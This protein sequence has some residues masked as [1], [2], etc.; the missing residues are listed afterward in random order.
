MKKRSFKLLFLLQLEAERLA[1]HLK[2]E[3]L[4]SATTSTTASGVNTARS[5]AS[6]SHLADDPS[7]L[8]IALPGE[9]ATDEKGT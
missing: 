1:L 7:R 2:N 8:R 9:D 5:D 3:Q 4:K 6:S